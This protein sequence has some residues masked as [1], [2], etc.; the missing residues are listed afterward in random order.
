[1]DKTEVQ[2]LLSLICSAENIVFLL[3]LGHG[4][5]LAVANLVSPDIESLDKVEQEDIERGNGQQDLIASAVERL[6][7]VTVDVGGD[8]VTTLH[9]HVVQRGADG[10]RADTVAVLGIPADENGV[11]VWVT[12][13]TGEEGIANPRVALGRENDEGQ[14]PGEDPDVGQGG[15]N[16]TLLP[17]D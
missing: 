2:S 15:E 12:E 4:I 16:G 7:V 1:M 10:S 14:D 3:L 6:V 17:L 9:K 11:A 5:P 13:E 8:N